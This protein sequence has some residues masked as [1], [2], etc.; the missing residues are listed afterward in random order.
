[1]KT[2][3]KLIFLLI[4]IVLISG[5]DSCSSTDENFYISSSFPESGTENVPLQPEI[6]VVFT[7]PLTTRYSPIS[8]WFYSPVDPYCDDN[9]RLQAANAENDYTG[10]LEI[11][12][13]SLEFG[14]EKTPNTISYSNQNNATFHPTY[15]TFKPTLPL[16]PSTEYRVSVTS[17]FH[18]PCPSK[19]SKN[20]H[21]NDAYSLTFTTASE[22]P[23]VYIVDP[24]E[25]ENSVEVS[26]PIAITF[27][28]EMLA[29]T[30]TAN[31]DDMTCSGSVQVS[32]D[33]FTTC[34]K[35]L[36]NSTEESSLYKK[37]IAPL[38]SDTT[39]YLQPATNLTYNTSYKVKV[40]TEVTDSDGNALVEEYISQSGFTTE[41]SED[42]T[43]PTVSSIYPSSV[44]STEVTISTSVQIT[45]SEAMSIASISTN[46]T[47][48]QCTGTI[49]LSSD[50][51]TTCVQMA[52]EPEYNS[53]QT[54]FTVTPSENLDNG[55]QY[56]IKI[57]TDA[58]DISLNSLA[59]VYNSSYSNFTTTV[60]PDITNPTAY[61]TNPYYGQESAS[62]STSISVTFSEQMDTSTITV[63]TSDTS[64]SG[65]LQVSTDSSPNSCIKMSSAPSASNGNKTFTV[66]PSSSLLNDTPY[67]IDISESVTDTSG[68]NFGR[69]ISFFLTTPDETAPEVVSVVP[70]NGALVDELNPTI[71]ITFSEP[72]DVSTL[73]V[74]TDDD[75]C[76]T[77][78]IGLGIVQPFEGDPPI[79]LRIMSDPTV[80]NNNKTFTFTPDN[81]LT[82]SITYNIYVSATVRDASG[83]FLEDNYTVSFTVIVL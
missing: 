71:S 25:D 57:T 77:G 47:D 33:D 39:F 76:E 45:F 31:S 7:K 35:M 10:C 6:T 43:A 70:A 17:D 64:C 19:G 51:F 34:V 18:T 4:M 13:V 61:S 69:D 44:S 42:L 30:I 23:V 55:T 78:S 68:N 3:V 79:C 49:Q 20:N 75:S 14:E 1:M 15:L 2:F 11:E 28:E 63:N 48:T 72:M 62:I 52:S 82:S 81:P 9:I 8:D 59:E 38:S 24:A 60:Y 12:L 53:D 22:N 46:N 37:L 40:T 41:E 54:V 5:Q 32:S 67:F 36:D 80:Y 56:S 74:N 66:S 26:S 58:Q 50:N 83:N 29:S 16:Q 73:T 27:T 65:S 21:L